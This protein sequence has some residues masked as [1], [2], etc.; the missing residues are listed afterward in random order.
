MA[1][2]LSDDQLDIMRE[3]LDSGLAGSEVAIRVGCSDRAVYERR[4]RWNMGLERT[5]PSKSKRAKKPKKKAINRTHTWHEHHFDNDLECIHCGFTHPGSSSKWNKSVW[6][7]CESAPEPEIIQPPVSI[8][9]GRQEMEPR[10]HCTKRNH[11]MT[12]ENTYVTPQGRRECR[13]CRSIN[14]DR[15]KERDADKRA[16]MEER[17]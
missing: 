13:A 16:A 6:T 14:N 11:E 12:F 2:K 7:P 5:A 3:L 1:R 8:I 17:G 15:R 10:T 9:Q 4:Q